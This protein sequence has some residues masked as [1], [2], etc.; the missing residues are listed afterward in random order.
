[1]PEQTVDFDRRLVVV[2]ALSTFVATLVGVVVLFWTNQ[3][4][5]TNLTPAQ[6]APYPVVMSVSIMF[7]LLE[8]LV[9]GGVARFATEAY[10]ER[11]GDGFRDVI[12]SSFPLCAGMGALFAASGVV[13]AIYAD[14][15]LVVEPAQLEETQWMLLLTLVTQGFLVAL[16][17]LTL[18]LFVKQ[19]FVA[20][21][22]V[23]MSRELLR[24][25][26]IVYL[27]FFHSATV[28][29]VV[30]ATTVAST[31][32]ILVRVVLSKRALPEQK[33]QFS[34]FQ[35]ELARSITSFGAW[36][37]FGNITA[38]I[39]NTFD[40]L[41]LNRFGS[42]VDVAANHVAALPGRQLDRFKN[43][44]A[45]VV[46]PA[47][48]GFHVRSEEDRLASAY[49]RG[50]R[51]FLWV[52]L[53]ATAP[54]L[55]YSDA[56]ISLYVGDVYAIA[57]VALGL[58]SLRYMMRTSSAMLYQLA[59]AR[60]RIRAFQ[61]F[62][63]IATL[64]HIG[65]ASALVIVYEMGVLGVVY[66]ALCTS[67]VLHLTAFWPLG[68]KLGSVRIRDFLVQSLVRGYAPALSAIGFLVALKT[69]VPADTWLELGA[70]AA[71]SGVVYLIVLAIVLP[72]EDRDELRRAWGKIT[73]KLERLRG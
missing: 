56:L 58:A 33:L 10:A 60:A 41:L 32:S 31:L 46:E 22:V 70:V 2:N 13:G 7:A 72:A 35:P 61:T 27:L 48:I 50:N 25:A 53:A 9:G 52:M 73:G 64:F 28:L 14:R 44:V 55:V 6:F 20:M 59:V 62:N 11:G 1:M 34:R 12:A 4:L 36:T 15:I 49:L 17:P 51:Y 30:V 40:V 38:Q 66:S 47:L 18:G 24:A 54:L 45:R 67:V 37:M 5:L 3:Y 42:D 65:L 63:S 69:R 16:T 19:R 71:A 8:S 26:L 43:N 57:G 39:N 68:L 21:N 29:W 23:N